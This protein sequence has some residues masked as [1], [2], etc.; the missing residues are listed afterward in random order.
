MQRN[1]QGTPRKMV[2]TIPKLATVPTNREHRPK[3]GRRRERAHVPVPSLRNLPV[4]PR[5][6]L[7]MC[8]MRS[9]KMPGLHGM[10]LRN[11]RTGNPHHRIKRWQHLQEN[12]AKQDLHK[13]GKH[14]AR[15]GMQRATKFPARTHTWP[16]PPTGPQGATPR[17]GQTERQEGNPRMRPLRQHNDPDHEGK[18][19]T[20]QT[21]YHLQPPKRGT[22]VR[23]STRIHLQEQEREPP[24][25]RTHIQNK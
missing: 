25:G 19:P 2:T 22:D 14:D 4:K 20:A 16:R 12:L 15:N 5:P 8:R 9:A 6:T 1:R 11:R 7:Q 3:R 17:G 24:H 10:Y 21:R 13:R 23:S 18:R